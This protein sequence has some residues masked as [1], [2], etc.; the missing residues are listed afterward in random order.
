MTVEDGVAKIS[1]TAEDQPAFEKAVLMTGNALGIR[2]VQAEALTVAAPAEAATIITIEKGDTLW[3]VAAKH[4]GNG[5][6]YTEIVE[7][8]K[9]VIKN[10]D[11]IFPGQKIRIP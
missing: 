11:L 9:E 7:A 8:N 4:L 2:E 6:K 1:G 3:A 5:A 10:A